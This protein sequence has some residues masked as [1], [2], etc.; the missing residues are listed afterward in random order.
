MDDI[1]ISLKL[2]NLGGQFLPVADA[3]HARPRVPPVKSL[4]VKTQARQN[5]SWLDLEWRLRKFETSTLGMQNGLGSR[6]LLQEESLWIL[7][8]WTWND[9]K[10]QRITKS[11]GQ[12]VFQELV[13]KFIDGSFGNRFQKYYSCLSKIGWSDAEQSASFLAADTSSR[14]RPSAGRAFSQGPELQLQ[15]CA[16]SGPDKWIHLLAKSGLGNWSTYL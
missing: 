3:T 10:I 15:G 1:N 16:R 6:T 7:M 12:V 9:R 5:S 8:R 13:K 14:R 4:Q 2:E 11:L